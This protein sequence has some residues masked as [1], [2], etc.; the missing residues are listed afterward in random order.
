MACWFRVLPPLATMPSTPSST[1]AQLRVCVRLS[2]KTPLHQRLD[3]QAGTALVP[4]Q[5][6][7]R[8]V[9]HGSGQVEQAR[10]LPAG[11]RDDQRGPCARSSARRNCRR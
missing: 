8:V 10:T 9:A 3:V 1:S 7:R 5:A 4:A 6:G 2:M 11:R